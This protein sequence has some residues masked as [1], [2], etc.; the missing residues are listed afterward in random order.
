MKPIRT[1]ITHRTDQQDRLPAIVIRESSD[2]RTGH[3]LQEAEHG[4]EEAS[5]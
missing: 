1:K 2:N 4:T 3:E 5:E